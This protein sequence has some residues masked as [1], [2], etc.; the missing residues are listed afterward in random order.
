VEH[1]QDGGEAG[2]VVAADDDVVV[3][4]AA[5]QEVVEGFVEA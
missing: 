3:A 2:G 5:F 4:D 1:S